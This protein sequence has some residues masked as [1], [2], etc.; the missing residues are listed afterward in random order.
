MMDMLSMGE[1]GAFVWSSFGITLVAV[2]I[3][4]YQGVRRHA[5]MVDQLTTRLKAMESDYET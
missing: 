1:Y 4:A 3:C 5:V 2:V